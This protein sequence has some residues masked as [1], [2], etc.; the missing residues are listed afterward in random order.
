M[1]CGCLVVPAPSL[2]S[3][4]DFSHVDGTILDS[5]HRVTKTT[6]AAALELRK[7]DIPLVLVSAR[8]PEALAAIRRELRCIEPTVCYSGA[9]VDR[10]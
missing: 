7:R 3:L 9:L 1:L 8:M 6:A 2:G 10:G 5:E 4:G